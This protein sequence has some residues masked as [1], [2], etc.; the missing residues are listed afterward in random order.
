MR[1]DEIFKNVC[2]EYFL[3]EDTKSLN[4]LRFL[5][6]GVWLFYEL[7]GEDFLDRS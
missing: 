7:V 1:F 6:T 3:H 5:K 4:N 2:S